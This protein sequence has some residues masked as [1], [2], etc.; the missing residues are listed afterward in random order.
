MTVQEVKDKTEKLPEETVHKYSNKGKDNL[1]ESVFIEGKP[2]FL[3]YTINQDKDKDF[4]VSPPYIQEDI[5]IIKP[6][7]DCPYQP[8]NFKTCNE[9]NLLYLQRAKRLTIDELYQQFKAQVRLFNDVD[10]STVNLLGA[11]ITASYFQD[12]FSTTPYLIV[13]GD[14]GTGKSALGDTFESLAYRAVNVTNTTD[15]F[16][17]RIF[18]TIESGQVTIIAEEIDRLDEKSEVMS[19]LKEGYQ[20]NAKV[21]RMSNENTKMEFFYPYSQKI[22][23]G[24]RSPSET[25]AKGVNDRSFKIKTYKGSPTYK[26]KEIRNPQGNKERQRLLD[27]INYLRNLAL[28]YKLRHFRDALIEVNV[29]LD[30]RDEELCKPTLQIFYTLGAT[31]ETMKELEETFQVFLNMKIKRKNASRDAIIYPAVKETVEKLGNNI[32]SSEFWNEVTRI[33]TER[34]EGEKDPDNP[35]IFQSSDF[36]LYKNT[37]TTLCCDKFGAETDHTY[38]GSII[39]FDVDHLNKVSKLYDNTKGIKTVPVDPDTPDT[40]DTQIKECSK[41][42]IENNDQIFMNPSDLIKLSQGNNDNNKDHNMTHL[43]YLDQ[44]ASGASVRQGDSEAC[45]ALNPNNASHL[46]NDYPP[47]CYRCEF[48][49]NSKQEYENHCSI[50]HPNK[51]GYPN[52]AGIEA[53]HLE[54]QDMDWE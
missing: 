12:R 2:Y 8:Y 14:N 13:V 44:S 54:P 25:K 43:P 18:G 46:Y 21:P 53:D 31:E 42:V 40:P 1:S 27:D 32:Q 37:L 34:Q 38:K 24:E 33:L 9:P 52:L 6:P 10:E 41:C 20:P 17:F 45:E 26:I 19:I 11:Y 15:A 36:R 28:C 48:V 49:P 22:L 23:I 29:G 51:S 39:T 3:A 35:N 30:G 16:W 47:H 50:K 4:F 7:L 5:R